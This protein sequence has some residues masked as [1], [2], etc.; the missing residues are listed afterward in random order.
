MRWKDIGLAAAPPPTAPSTCPNKKGS[1]CEKKEFNLPFFHLYCWKANYNAMRTIRYCSNWIE[2]EIVQLDKYSFSPDFQKPIGQLSLCL[3][4]SVIC[5]LVRWKKKPLSALHWCI[6]F[7]T[8]IFYPEGLTPC[9]G[10]SR[11]SLELYQSRIYLIFQM[12]LLGE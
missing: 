7:K 6:I 3:S 2:R 11:T 1:A 4:K 10:F 12:I 5:C 8:L 9:I